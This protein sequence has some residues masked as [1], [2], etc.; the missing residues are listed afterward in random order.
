MTNIVDPDQTALLGAV[1]A[2]STQ[3]AQAIFQLTKHLTLKAPITTAADDIFVF[4]LFFREK[5][6]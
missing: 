4:F 1:G 2:G 5:K 6:S 3:F